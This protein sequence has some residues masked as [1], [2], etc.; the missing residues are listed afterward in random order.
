MSDSEIMEQ[1]TYLF[2]KFDTNL[3]GYLEEKEIF[4]MLVYLSGL[5]NKGFDISNQDVEFL[6]QHT[7]NP[8]ERR[9]TKQELF[10]FYTK[11]G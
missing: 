2:R 11:N 8:E 5:S 9:I 4:N 10:S 3:S 1:I 6:L 7:I